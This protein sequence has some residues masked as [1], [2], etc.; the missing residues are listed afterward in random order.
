MKV[1]GLG[2]L[3]RQRFWL[4]TSP[5]WQPWVV[6][7]LTQVILIFP[8]FQLISI[9]LYITIPKNKRKT[10]IIWEK[11]NYCTSCIKKAKFC[12]IFLWWVYLLN[13]WVDIGERGNNWYFT[14][15]C[16]ITCVKRHWLIGIK[17]NN[18]LKYYRLEQQP[19]N[20][21]GRP[22]RA[23]AAGRV[24]VALSQ[25]HFVVLF[26]SHTQKMGR[27][28]IWFCQKQPQCAKCLPYKCLARCKKYDDDDDD[29]D[30]NNNNNNNNNKVIL[31][32]PWNR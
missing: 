3:T 20:M 24:K 26:L 11:K 18:E 25:P 22:A 32:N 28:Q 14:V 9:Q 15:L 2:W 19:A 16:C 27:G 30:D 23:A 1:A 10:K 7:F 8:L 13:L 31:L 21:D 6:N 29:D 17:S 12:F 4:A 5:Y